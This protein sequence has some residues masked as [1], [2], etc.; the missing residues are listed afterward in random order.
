MAVKK[1]LKLWLSESKITD[2]KSKTFYMVLPFKVPN[3]KVF[4]LRSLTHEL[5]FNP[6]LAKKLFLKMTCNNGFVVSF[7]NLKLYMF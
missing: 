2:N 4:N 1:N 3:N 7:K 5:R 6:N